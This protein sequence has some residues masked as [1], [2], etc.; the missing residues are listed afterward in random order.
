MKIIN[1]IRPSKLTGFVLGNASYQRLH[2]GRSFER[3]HVVVYV[4]DFAHVCFAQ[5]IPLH[6]TRGRPLL[7]VA[8]EMVTMRICF[9]LPQDGDARKHENE[10]TRQ[11]FLHLDN[12]TIG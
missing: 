4:G 5:R 7:M 2:V 3:P 9:D 11:S 12:Y 6:S 8:A 1:A 10:K